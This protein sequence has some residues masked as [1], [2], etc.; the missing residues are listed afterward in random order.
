MQ[1]WCRREKTQ[2]RGIREIY[3][4]ALP[5][6]VPH[7]ITNTNN[8]GHKIRNVAATHMHHHDS[9][10]RPSLSR[11]P[12]TYL[13]DP[14]EVETPL[15]PRSDVISATIHLFREATLPAES[16]SGPLFV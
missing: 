7:V 14:G 12:P 2:T 11:K 16:V 3:V 9:T 8:P 10:D 4:C 5:S 6:P 13:A 15:V 1:G